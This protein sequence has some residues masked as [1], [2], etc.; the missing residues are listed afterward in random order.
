MDSLDFL[1]DLPKNQSGGF[2]R[3]HNFDVKSVLLY[4]KLVLRRVWRVIRRSQGGP[5]GGGPRSR[6]HMRGYEV[7]GTTC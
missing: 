6:V 4:L 5:I 7:S 1:D 3:H 2:K